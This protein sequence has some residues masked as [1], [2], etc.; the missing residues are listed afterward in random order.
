MAK[1]IPPAVTRH[2]SHKVSDAELAEL[3][4]A[5]NRSELPP[6]HTTAAPINVVPCSTVARWFL[7]ARRW[8]RG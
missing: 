6:P 4:N 8:W 3:L 1:R 5:M 2:L 7:A